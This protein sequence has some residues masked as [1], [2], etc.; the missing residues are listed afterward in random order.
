M[1]FIDN[2]TNDRDIELDNDMDSP[3]E[4]RS[5]GEDENYATGRDLQ[6]NEF[7]VKRTNPLDILKR[8]VSKKI[9]KEPITVKVPERPAISLIFNTDLDVDLLAAYQ[10]KATVKIKG[11]GSRLNEMQLAAM[12]LFRLT[13]GI[14]VNGEQ[15]FEEDGAP[16][17]LR[18]PTLADDLGILSSQS[19]SI[20]RELFGYD[21]HIIVAMREVMTACGY[22][23]DISVDEDADED[24]PN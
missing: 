24:F 6:N 14:K 3:T 16:V 1:G 19:L 2:Q 23:D 4:E 8:E 15:V 5:Y 7:K 22:G 9:E 20:L 18:T 10:R 21:G 17:T 11:G 12:I 13:A